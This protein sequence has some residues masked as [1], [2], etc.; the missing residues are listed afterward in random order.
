MQYPTK[1]IFFGIY[2]WLNLVCLLGS[3]FVTLEEL[4]DEKDLLDDNCC[5]THLKP[6]VRRKEDNYFFALSKYQQQL[7]DV[8]KQNPG[9]VQPSYRLNEVGRL[10]YIFEFLFYTLHLIGS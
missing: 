1:S 2:A 10:E 3:P 6:C 9:F 7:E 5:P 4:Q 8:I